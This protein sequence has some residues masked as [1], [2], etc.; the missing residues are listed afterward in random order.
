[1]AHDIDDDLF[2]S[3]QTIN[4]EKAQISRKTNTY[5]EESRTLSQKITYN[6]KGRRLN[7]LLYSRDGK[8]AAKDVY[9]YDST[10]EL[11]EVTGYNMDGSL[12]NKKVYTRSSDRKSIE[13]VTYN[14]GESASSNK[15]IHTLNDAGQ[16]INLTTFDAGG[17]PSNKVIISYDGKGKIREVVMCSSVKNG[18]IVP[19]SDGRSVVLSDDIKDKMKGIFPCFDKLLTSRTVFTHDDAGHLIETATYTHDNSLIGREAYTCEF[20]SHG[21]WIKQI[22]SKWNPTANKFEPTDVTYRTIIY[23]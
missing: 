16:Q 12:I 10:G 20:D 9:S 19:G 11:R 14:D 8:L 21:N 17:A 4:I 2:G 3:V 13:E 7:A 18:M 1:M 22:K 15:T 23:Y 5:V 6:P